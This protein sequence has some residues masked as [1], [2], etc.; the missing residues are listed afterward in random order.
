MTI[1]NPLGITP[2][3]GQ[4]VSSDSSGNLSNSGS[5]HWD[6]TNTRLLIGTASGYT[7]VTTD[8]LELSGGTAGSVNILE[9][10]QSPR[11]FSAAANDG[12]MLLGA[13]TSPGVLGSHD[14]GAIVMGNNPSVN[15]GG[16]GL[17]Q[18][19]V[20][21]T[22]SASSANGL[23]LQCLTT[24][25]N[26]I[27]EIDFYTGA[28]VK[29]MSIDG[30][31]NVN[32]V[33]LTAS[34]PVFTDASKNLTSTGTVGAT[35]GGT[36][37]STY[38]L[39][40]TLYASA[41]N[42]LSKLT[43]NTT[44]VKQYLSQTGTGSVSAAPA[45]ATIS[46][47]DVTGAALTKTDDTNVTL[48]LGGTPATALLN[49]SSLTLGWTGQLS[50]ARGG[51]NVGS[52]TTNGVLFNNGTQNTTSSSFSYTTGLLTSTTNSG[53]FSQIRA[54]YTTTSGVA[55]LVADR[56]D[57][58][59]GTARM[60][61]RTNGSA[62]WSVEL[63]PADASL[64]FYDETNSTDRV[65]I[66]QTGDLTALTGNI[67]V[68]TPGKTI[69]IKEGSNACK[70][71]VTLVAG[72]ATVSTTAV[73][74]NDM[75]VL[76]PFTAGGTPGSIPFPTITNGASFSLAGLSTDTSTYKWLIVKAA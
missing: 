73:G 37:Q 75:I 74:T 60:Q 32:V 15:N 24:S 4:L 28:S 13:A 45:W 58:A 8:R 27:S 42:V 3:N 51:N 23:F 2:L 33:N 76:S 48:T 40:D 64:H 69:E 5:M 39:G 31:G 14:Y 9:V 11:S 35:S 63:R 47:A 7:G 18:F 19:R 56:F 16:A 43:G 61:Y 21:G 66:S 10:Y 72:A 70:G 62:V 59:T 34:L 50:I 52:Q 46:G 41:T 22:A 38:T 36:S 20:G 44:A 6:N 68:N 67:L 29:R 55:G 17:F 30:S 25:A 53:G 65:T 71:T 57:Q 1:Q 26:S 49:A 12:F 54:Q